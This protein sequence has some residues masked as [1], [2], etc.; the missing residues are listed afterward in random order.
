MKP[1]RIRMTDDLVMQY[2]LYKEMDI[3]VRNS[4]SRFSFFRFFL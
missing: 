3:V 1:H 2:G 4:I